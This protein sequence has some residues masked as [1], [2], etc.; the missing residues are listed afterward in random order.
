MRRSAHSRASRA[1]RPRTHSCSTRCTARPAH[2]ERIVRDFRRCKE[3]E[4]LGREAQQQASRQLKWYYD[5]DGMLVIKARLPAEAGQMFIKAIQAAM[6]ARFPRPEVSAETPNVKFRPDPPARKADALTVMAESFLAQGAAALKGGDRHQIVV[7]VDA[8]TFRDSTAGRCNFEHGPSMSAETARRLACDCSIVPID[9]ER[10]R[11][12]AQRRPQ[13]TQHPS[14]HSA[15]PQRERSRLLPLSWL[16]EHALSRRS[17]HP[18]LGARR[19]DEALEPAAAGI[20]PESQSIGT[21][22]L[23]LNRPEAL[24]ANHR[25]YFDWARVGDEERQPGANWVGAWYARNLRIFN[26]LL[27]M[28]D[29]SQ[30][31]ILVI[32]GQGH[33]YLLRQFATESGAFR[34]IDVDSVLKTPGR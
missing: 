26:N 15:R 18:A 20:V 11:R 5:A 14:G 23:Q 17:S 28:S 12:T 27:R 29:R 16:P 34:L 2:V 33:A 32:Y 30:D 7:H 24:L 22:L 8:E 21:W 9:R 31:R 4:E 3:A 25:N 13:D 19:R 10:R 1:R 6:R